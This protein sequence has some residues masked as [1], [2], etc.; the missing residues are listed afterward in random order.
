MPYDV[1]HSDIDN[2]IMVHLPIQGI[3]REIALIK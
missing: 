1:L 2:I 3:Y